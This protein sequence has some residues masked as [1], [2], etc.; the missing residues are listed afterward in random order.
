M[1]SPPGPCEAAGPPTPR[2]DDVIV[3]Q[4]VQGLRGLEQLNGEAPVGLT[5]FRV[6]AGV[7]V[8]EKET[9]RAVKERRSENLVCAQGTGCGPPSRDPVPSKGP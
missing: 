9:S 6:A 2:D 7:I 4:K 5:G 3:E 8:D 1:R